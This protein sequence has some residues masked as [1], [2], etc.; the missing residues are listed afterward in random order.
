MCCYGQISALQGRHCKLSVIPYKCEDQVF[1]TNHH[2]PKKKHKTKN[3]VPM[4]DSS[5]E[6]KTYDPEEFTDTS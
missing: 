1:L 2:P 6:S 5:T 3:I 4:V